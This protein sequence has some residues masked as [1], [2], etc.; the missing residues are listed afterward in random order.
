M[1]LGLDAK[2][3]GSRYISDMNDSSIGAFTV[4]DFDA[5]YRFSVWGKKSTLQ[6][7]V[8]NLFNQQYYSRTSTVG[9]AVPIVFANG[10]TISAS[11]P[12]LY[13]GAPITGYVTL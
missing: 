5:E 9:N 13:V 11:T 3:T 6:L 4:V 2:Y 12:Y 8:Y 10:D 1:T 7:N